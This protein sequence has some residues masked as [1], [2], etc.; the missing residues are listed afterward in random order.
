MRKAGYYPET[1]AFAVSS[2]TRT[3]GNTGGQN[4]RNTYYAQRHPLCA[5]LFLTSPFVGLVGV[6][7]LIEKNLRLCRPRRQMMARTANGGVGLATLIVNQMPL[8]LALLFPK[9]QV[10]RRHYEEVQSRSCRPPSTRWAPAT[11]PS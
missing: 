9:E 6:P 3:K 7:R 5:S 10:P 11:A 2:R 8:C 1:C 4:L